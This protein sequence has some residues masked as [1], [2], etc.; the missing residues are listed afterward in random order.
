VWGRVFL[1]AEVG[2]EELE[3]LDDGPGLVPSRSL[4]DLSGLVEVELRWILNDGPSPRT[5]RPLE[6]G[7]GALGSPGLVWVEHGQGWPVTG[8]CGQPG[9]ILIGC[10]GQPDVW[11]SRAP[12]Q[13]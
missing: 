13:G 6:S 1:A 8:C 11:V 7:P 12:G 3:A 10:R 4:Q 9:F 5:F 2:L